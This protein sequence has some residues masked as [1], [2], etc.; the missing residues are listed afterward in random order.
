VS[1]DDVKAVR[2]AVGRFARAFAATD[3]SALARLWDDEYPYPAYQP[4]EI[5]APLLNVADI[6]AYFDNLKSVIRG[7]FDIEPRHLQL[8]VIGDF[9]HVF[10][11]AT[12]TLVFVREDVRLEGEVRQSFVLRKRAGEWRFIHYHESRLTPGLERLVN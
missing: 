8:D 2:T 5:D 7:V 11:T 12:A 6:F 1:D 3:G 10:S 4:E 9:A